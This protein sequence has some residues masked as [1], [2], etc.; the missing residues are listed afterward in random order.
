MCTCMLV[1]L[2]MGMHTGLK[3]QSFV[4]IGRDTHMSCLLRSGPAFTKSFLGHDLGFQMCML[5]TNMPKSVVVTSC[6]YGT[7]YF[8]SN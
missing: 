8:S 7:Q 6:P 4:P 1:F 3:T 2:R 5:A